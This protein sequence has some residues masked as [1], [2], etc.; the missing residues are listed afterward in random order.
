MWW[1]CQTKYLVY[2]IIW[3]LAA[4]VA[5]FPIICLLFSSF[6]AVPREYIYKI[7]RNCRAV[8]VSRKK[9]ILLKPVLSATSY[10]YGGWYL[11]SKLWYFLKHFVRVQNILNAYKSFRTPTKHFERV[12]N[13]SYAY[14]TFCT[15]TK[16][17]VRVQN[18]SYEYKTFCTR[19]KHFVC[20]QNSQ[21]TTLRWA[22]MTR[23]KNVTRGGAGGPLDHNSQR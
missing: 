2:I 1:I 18:I 20:V 17:F 21:C 19:T 9:I 14:K 6:Y 13:I 16:H 22:W 3:Q 8:N 11:P 7:T 5:L 23:C 4:V 10:T 15:R 12:Q